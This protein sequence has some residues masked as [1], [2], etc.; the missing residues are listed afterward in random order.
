M[1]SRLQIDFHIDEVCGPGVDPSF[2]QMLSALGY[3]ARARPKPLIERLIQWREVH[4]KRGGASR[5]E[6][7]Q[8]CLAQLS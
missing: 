8:V 3:V 5:S 1:A 4:A 6:L 7:S 2:D